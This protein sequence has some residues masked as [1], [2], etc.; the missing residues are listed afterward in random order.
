MLSWAVSEA[1]VEQRDQR[2]S[3][4]SVVNCTLCPAEDSD[5]RRWTVSVIHDPRRWTVSVIHDPRR[6]TVGK[7]D[8]RPAQ[9]DG[10]CYSRP[11]QI[12]GVIHDPRRQ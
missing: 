5:P 9:V 8:S 11:A 2:I 12:D 1:H 10:K 6:W 7:C 3:L 4:F